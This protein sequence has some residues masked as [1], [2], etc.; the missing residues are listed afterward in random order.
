MSDKSTI[1]KLHKRVQTRLS[2][3]ARGVVRETTSHT[4]PEH[5]ETLTGMIKHSSIMPRK[6]VFSFPSFLKHDSITLDF[7]YP[8]YNTI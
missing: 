5:F 7:L 4:N 3:G 2:Q 6:I 8:Q 1:N